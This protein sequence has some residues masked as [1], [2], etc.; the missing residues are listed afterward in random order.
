MPNPFDQNGVKPTEEFQDKPAAE[1]LADLVG[2]GK[3]YANAEELARAFAHGQHHISTVE[4]ENA[5]YREKLTATTTVDDIMKQL[6]GSQEPPAPSDNTGADDPSTPPTPEPVD[7]EATVKKLLEQQTQATTANSNK[8][9]VLAKM[10]AQFGS[11]A[12]EIWDKAASELNVDLEQLASTSPAAIYKLVGV[13]S[14]VQPQQ[15][16]VP[17]T[18]DVTP[19]QLDQTQ[20]PPEGSKRLVKYLQ[21]KGE[22]TRSQAYQL[23]LAYSADPTKYNA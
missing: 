16:G 13:D 9:E 21:D 23:K 3:K 22:L 20:R 14:E 5:G 12:G 19:P 4:S 6:K 8:S 7:I 10:Q 15:Q 17:L 2:E 11:K 18:G 1:F